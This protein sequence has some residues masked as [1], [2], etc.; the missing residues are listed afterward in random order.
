MAV[1]TNDDNKILNFRPICVGAVCFLT[2]IYCAVNAFLQSDLL[3]IALPMLV[4]ALLLVLFLVFAKKK[5]LSCILVV[6][7]LVIFLLG[8]GAFGVKANL[9]KNAKSP[10]I[11]GQFVGTVDE[12]KVYYDGNHEIIFRN[13][14]LN[15]EQ[16]SSKT[17][18]YARLSEFDRA[19]RVGDTYYL[20]CEQIIPLYEQFKD[21]IELYQ[22]VHFSIS[23]N[24][25]AYFLP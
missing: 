20:N 6:C 23:S 2:G 18:Y 5:K 24:E 3:I 9:A 19:P 1:F 25:K 12:I 7:Y 16:I 22:G 21:Y 13:C 11:D 10:Y 17:V 8:I 4:F 14:T 15:G